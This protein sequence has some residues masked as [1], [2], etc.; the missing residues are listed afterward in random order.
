MLQEGDMEVLLVIYQVSEE[1]EE[2]FMVNYTFHTYCTCKSSAITLLII[3]TAFPPQQNGGKLL[4][5]HYAY[6]Y[7]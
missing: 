2:Y 6:H 1:P 3:Y 5:K 7:I 4:T